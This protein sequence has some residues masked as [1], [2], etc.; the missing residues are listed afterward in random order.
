MRWFLGRY[1][2]ILKIVKT[3][4]KLIVWEEAIRGITPGS[5][6]VCVPNTSGITSV[7][8]ASSL[9]RPTAEISRSSPLD[10]YRILPIAD[11]LYSSKI[12]T[13]SRYIAWNQRT[14]NPG[15]S[16][17]QQYTAKCNPNLCK[18]LIHWYFS[19]RGF[20]LPPTR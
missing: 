3:T 5:V 2:S 15:L 16:F 6:S 12:S 14:D 13:C 8:A 4:L 11:Y 1:V 9:S 20:I 10:S 17:D 19:C 7:C 18:G